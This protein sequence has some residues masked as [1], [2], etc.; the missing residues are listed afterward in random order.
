MGKLPAP[1]EA[2]MRG[3]NGNRER[4]PR[5]IRR[6]PTSLRELSSDVTLLHS[7]RW[8][9]VVRPLYIRNKKQKGAVRP[10]PVAASAGSSDKAG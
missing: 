2:G 6:R 10:P 5:R 8:I 3:S 9:V 7:G 1:V 4:L